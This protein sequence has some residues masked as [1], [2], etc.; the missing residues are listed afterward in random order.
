MHQSMSGKSAQKRIDAAASKYAYLI[1][2]EVWSFEYAHKLLA[3]VD[4]KLD[5]FEIAGL[6]KAI[7]CFQCSEEIANAL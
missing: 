3:N 4:N 6:A 1:K 7:A 5:L 2:D